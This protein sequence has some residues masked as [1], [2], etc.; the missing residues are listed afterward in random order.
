VNGKHYVLDFERPGDIGT[1]LWYNKDVLKK[2]GITEDPAQLALD[3]KWTWDKFRSMLQSCTMDT[4]NDGTKDVFGIASF[5]GYSDIAFALSRS[6]GAG[7]LSQ[8]GKKFKNSYETPAFMESINFFDTL[9]NTDKVFRIYDNM[10][11]GEE[12]WNNMPASDTIFGEFRNGKFG[13][14][15]ARMW[16]GNQQLK[17]Y[18]E[19]GY[20]LVVYPKGPKASDY[21]LDAQT[22]GGYAL[23]TTNK[24]YK[25][26]AIIFNALAHPVEGYEDDAVMQETIAADFFQDNDAL[27]YKMY[28]LAQKKVKV[29]FGYG[30]QQLYA[31]VNHAIIE[32][33]FWHIDTPAAAVEGLKGLT[34]EEVTNTYKHLYD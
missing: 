26:S 16:L 23:T 30:V 4:N 7:M 3:G 25:K 5:T 22:M 18:M 8:D 1:I 31:Q 14:L 9:V 11:G 12:T 27:S 2:A 24:D 33:V 6:N 13:F 34:N 28:E 17:P 10:N 32:S 15:S 29:D 20:G 19:N 21:I